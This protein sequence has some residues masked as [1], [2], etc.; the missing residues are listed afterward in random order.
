MRLS[1]ELRLK[2]FGLVLQRDTIHLPE[3]SSSRRF[4]WIRVP[5]SK[6]AQAV[7]HVHGQ[8][9]RVCKLFE[10]EATGILYGKTVFRI[11]GE[12]LVS[13]DYQ[14]LRKIG[15]K[16]VAMLRH[17]EID[18]LCERNPNAIASQLSTIAHENP[19][20]AN[21]HSLAFL[22]AELSFLKS[23]ITETWTALPMAN[24]RAYSRI[25]ASW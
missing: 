21:L 23:T 14:I 22:A 16:N 24:Q 17:I 3:K 15:R 10:R 2:I 25:L 5:F 12:E 20:L 11:S 19:E 9:L 8:V 1:I 4:R 18:E 13:F 7:D 6:K